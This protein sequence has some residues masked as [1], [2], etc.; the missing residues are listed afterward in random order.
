MTLSDYILK[1]PQLDSIVMIRLIYNGG[2]WDYTNWKIS[3]Q[4]IFFF[5]EDMK[6]GHILWTT[7]T[8]K[9]VDDTH[10]I[11]QPENKNIG[12]EFFYGGAIL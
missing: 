1:N 2:Y 11:Y 3:G 8:I 9:Q 7:D 12:L 10:I 5:N 4:N 6:V